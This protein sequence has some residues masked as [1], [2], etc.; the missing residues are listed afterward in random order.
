MG[1]DV[2]LDDFVKDVVRR[3]EELGFPR[4]YTLDE[5][6]AVLKKK[7]KAVEEQVSLVDLDEESLPSAKRYYVITDHDVL[8]E[9]YSP[10]EKLD[11]FS[12]VLDLQNEP[13]EFEFTV[14]QMWH[15]IQAGKRINIILESED[16]I[17]MSNFH[18]QGIGDK[19]YYEMCVLDG[20][21]EKDCHLGNELFHNYLKCLI[22]AGYIK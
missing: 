12:M 21:D 16:N 3:Y 14:Q 9:L 5:I 10:A 1:F 7:Y 11:L 17:H 18:L 6:G 4:R 2:Y 8:Q 20:I 15:D 13:E 22:Y 19:L